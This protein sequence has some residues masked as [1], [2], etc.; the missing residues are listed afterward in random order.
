MGVFGTGLYSRDFATDLRGTISA[1]LCLPFDADKLADTVC[2]SQPNIANLAAAEDHS[3]FWLVM[4]GQFAKRSIVCGRVR[5]KALQI[6]DCGSDL[7]A[8]AKLDVLLSARRVRDARLL[9]GIAGVRQTGRDENHHH[10]NRAV[11][12]PRA[13]RYT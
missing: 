8:H 2:E 4:A 5:D 10:R 12:E 7:A 13:G 3:T 9:Q 6:I 11:R 1:V